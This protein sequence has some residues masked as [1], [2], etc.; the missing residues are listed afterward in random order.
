MTITTWRVP[1]SNVLSTRNDK[2]GG[3][4]DPYHKEDRRNTT[5][6]QKKP[7]IISFK[8]KIISASKKFMLVVYSQKLLATAG[9][10]EM[11]K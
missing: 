11:E 4:T 2:I 8:N 9:E 1:Y 3:D 7:A 5:V 6:I 10:K